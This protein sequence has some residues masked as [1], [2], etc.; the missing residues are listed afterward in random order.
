MSNEDSTPLKIIAYLMCFIAPIIVGI[1]LKLKEIADVL[2][3][4]K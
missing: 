2:E 4:A 1:L 3:R